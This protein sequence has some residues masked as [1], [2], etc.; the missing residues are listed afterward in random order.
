[1]DF[2]NTKEKYQA[3][4]NKLPEK[5]NYVGVIGSAIVPLEIIAKTRPKKTVLFDNNQYQIEL[6][7]LYKDK[8]L[9]SENRIDFIKQISGLEENELKKLNELFNDHSYD[10]RNKPKE[11]LMS[12]NLKNRFN[13]FENSLDHDLFL[14]GRSNISNLCFT[15]IDNIFNNDER[16]NS[17]KETLS[18]G[19][20]YTENVDL[21]QNSFSK[22]INQY[23]NFLSKI[24]LISLSNVIP[25]EEDEPLMY[26]NEEQYNQIIQ[27]LG[28]LKTTKNPLVMYGLKSKLNYL[29]TL[30]KTEY[31]HI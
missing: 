12:L 11:Y 26:I 14:S 16:F 22:T 10:A 15:G 31:K 23:F 21:T 19:K 7:H 8:I 1:M 27:N 29:D 6:F 20:V 9:N 25:G 2:T 24:G 30:L 3:L 17:L 4:L 13:G 18:K 28:N 5:Q